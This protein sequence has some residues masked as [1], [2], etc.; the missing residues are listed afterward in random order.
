VIFGRTSPEAVSAGRRWWSVHPRAART[1][2]P[3]IPAV[4]SMP[5]VATPLASAP[6]AT[7]T[8]TSELGTTEVLRGTS[9]GNQWIEVYTSRQ[10]KHALDNVVAKRGRTGPKSM[11]V[12]DA[13]VR[14]ARGEVEVSIGNTVVGTLH[15]D[16]KSAY[17]A[18][19]E[20]ARRPVESS[21]IVVIEA[22]GHPG[23]HFKLYLPES[24]MLV[25]VNTLDPAIA[26]FLA[27]DR[28]GGLTLAKV[29]A[30]HALID[31]T[32]SRWWAG[33]PRSAW[34]VLT[35]SGTD[36]CDDGWTSTANTGPRP[37]CTAPIDVGRQAR[38]SDPNAVR[39]PGVRD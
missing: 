2:L 36:I 31:A 5:A 33:F 17:E 11:R 29:R 7:A 32:T 16:D 12:D 39:G 22:E 18:A 30:E 21:G 4:D 15:E 27:W 20:S 3:L 8:T 25:P 14:L 35:R 19:L 28:A 24:D 37:E 34:V 23:T 10:L 38:R 13:I 9:F 1:P 6:P 26:M